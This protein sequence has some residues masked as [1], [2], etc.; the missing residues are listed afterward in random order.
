M[1]SKYEFRMEENKGF[2]NFMKTG[3]VVKKLVDSYISDHTD[4]DSCDY[5]K[6]QY[7][8]RSIL[9]HEK[10]CLVRLA[11][12]TE[13][14]VTKMT[15]FCLRAQDVKEDLLDMELLTVSEVLKITMADRIPFHVMED[16]FYETLWEDYYHGR[17]EFLWPDGVWRKEEYV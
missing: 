13:T 17:M 5:C 2:E 16:T 6:K 14:D 12:E 11:K 7:V 10:H 3:A 9:V 15:T 8:L 4:S 1:L